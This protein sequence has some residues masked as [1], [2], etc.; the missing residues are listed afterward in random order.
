[1]KAIKWYLFPFS[2]V[3]SHIMMFF[4]LPP[5]KCRSDSKTIHEYLFQKP[6]K[7]VFHARNCNNLSFDI[8]HE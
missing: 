4:L 5:E 1:M 8:E 3:N 7:V 2:A 6:S